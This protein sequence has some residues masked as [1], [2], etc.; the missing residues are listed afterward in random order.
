MATHGWGAPRIPGELLEL[1]FDVSE[2]TVS[3]YMPR[4]PV[5]PDQLARW[6][7]FLRNHKEAIAAMDFFTVP[8]LS[9][10]VLYCLFII[11]HGR[12]RIVHFNATCNPTAQWVLQQLREAFP[13]DTAPA[14]LIFDR[15]AIF[16]AAVVRFVQALGANPRRIAYRSPWQTPLR[17]AGSVAADESSSTTCSCSI[18]GI[19]YGWF[20][21][22]RATTTTTD[23]ISDW[24]RI[25]P[26]DGRSRLGPRNQPRCSPCHVSAHCNAELRGARP[27]EDSPL[28]SPFR[29]RTDC[30]EA[31]ERRARQAAL[32]HRWKP[33]E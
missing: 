15:D 10:R 20:V 9:L 26:P 16:S 13:F 4:R 22:T 18:N 27:H 5:E 8:T 2:A 33:W 24:A 19:W 17:N 6:I 12:R 23:V 21:P 3:R 25:R 29:P 1:G 30:E 28:R 14:H 32:I 11:D 7:A 31:Q